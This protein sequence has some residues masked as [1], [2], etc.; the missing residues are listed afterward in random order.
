MENGPSEDVLPIKNGDIPAS[1]VCLPEGIS[2]VSIFLAIFFFGDFGVGPPKKTGLKK[3]A[4]FW[5]IAGRTVWKKTLY[6]VHN[7][8]CMFIYII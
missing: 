8:H 5:L 1:Y 4:L 6:I 3:T 2:F 7:R